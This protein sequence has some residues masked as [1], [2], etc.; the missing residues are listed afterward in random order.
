MISMKNSMKKEL[1]SA[2]RALVDELQSCSLPGVRLIEGDWPIKESK[3]R[4]YRARL[5]SLGRSRNLELWL[6]R[7]LDRPEPFFWFGLSRQVQGL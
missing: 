4:G 7:F 2:A 1:R 5:G 6:D 3:T